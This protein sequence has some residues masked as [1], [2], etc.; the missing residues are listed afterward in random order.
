MPA[1][2]TSDSAKLRVLRPQLRCAGLTIDASHQ[3][4]EAIVAS[5]YRST[6]SGKYRP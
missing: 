6:F 3:S 1:N 2:A 5:L 4:I